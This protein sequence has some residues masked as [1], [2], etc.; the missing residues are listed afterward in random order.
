MAT[1]FTTRF[2]ELVLATGEVAEKLGI[3][4]IDLSIGQVVADL[5]AANLLHIG[6]FDEDATGN[7]TRTVR[8]E[9]FQE[10]PLVRVPNAVGGDAVAAGDIGSFVYL[11]A[12]GAATT[13]TTTSLFGRVW[14][15]QSSASQVL[16]QPLLTMGPTGPEGPPGP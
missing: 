16:V 13:A 4:A 1:L 12:N 5:D 14:G 2:V 7:G 10:I 11:A 9:L 15:L 8:V 6:R 3:A